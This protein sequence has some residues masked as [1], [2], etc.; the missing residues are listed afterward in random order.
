MS[1]KS[2]SKKQIL[3]LGLVVALGA[4]MY[5]NWYYTKPVSERNNSAVKE[6]V[7]EQENLGEAQYVS[8]EGKQSFFDEASLKRAKAHS[9]AQEILEKALQNKEADEETKKEAREDLKKLTDD[10][11]TEADIESLI[12]AKIGAKS[13]VLIDDTVEVVVEKGKL[14]ADTALQIK[15]IIV[16]KTK[17]SSE[18]IT[19]VEVK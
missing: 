19:L 16:S 10:L 6:E 12:A 9:Q 8:A 13:L 11:Q 4:A 18:K 7:T 15:E 5:I 14:N 3:F 2:V 1:K 17:I